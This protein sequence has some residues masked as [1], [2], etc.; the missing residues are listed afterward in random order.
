[1]YSANLHS[2]AP[3][4]IKP[5]WTQRWGLEEPSLHCSKVG[6]P[7]GPS[8]KLP[9]W[10]SLPRWFSDGKHRGRHAR[11]QHLPLVIPFSLW[12]HVTSGVSSVHE[13]QQ[14]RNWGINLSQRVV[15]NH[16]RR[17][18]FSPHAISQLGILWSP[19]GDLTNVK[20]KQGA[21]FK[22]LWEI[23]V[24]WNLFI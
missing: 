24:L 22:C 6:L 17:S 5:V 21:G 15:N 23:S 3:I 11:W 7:A 12:D 2:N 20:G 19:V 1:M 14:E 18:A 13:S 4:S 9:L 10:P 8:A 16:K